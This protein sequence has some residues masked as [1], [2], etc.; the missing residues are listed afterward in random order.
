MTT[1]TIPFRRAP[2]AAFLLVGLAS[3]GACDDPV[4][5]PGG[6]AELVLETAVATFDATEVSVGADELIPI[7]LRNAGMDPLDIA[8]VELDGPDAGS[9]ELVEGAAPVRLA[10]GARHTILVD[11]LPESEGDKT[12]TLRIA[13]DD[14]SGMTAEVRMR[15]RG[16][17]FAYEQVDRQGLP[18][19]NTVFNHPS[20]I[21]PFDKTLYNVRTP[22]TDLA[23]YFDQF[24]VV[25]Q[26][27]GNSE[28]DA[29]ALAGVLLP[30][31]LPVSLGVERTS[32]AALTG[33]A[34]DD[35]AVDVVLGLL[36]PAPSLK[37]DNVDANDRRFRDEFPYVAAPNR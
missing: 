2:R 3:L 22:A 24:V 29:R 27:V 5:D 13:S 35:D 6:A 21:G 14:R 16:A 1:P 11:F 18:G 25:L 28:D 23:D 34:L 33:R 4:L 10:G 26:A 30:D 19:V 20:G 15:G 12:A 31:E 9:F 7:E 17:R 32:L 37:S 36:I 8:S